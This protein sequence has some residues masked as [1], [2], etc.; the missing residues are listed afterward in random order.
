MKRV[1]IKEESLQNLADAVRA[2][3]GTTNTYNIDEAVA[4]IADIDSSLTPELEDITITQNGI[5]YPNAYGFYQVTVDV[6]S[7][8]GGGSSDIPEEAF[9]LGENCN[10]KFY[11]GSWNWFIEN[12]GNRI[13]TNIVYAS[14]MFHSVLLSEIPFDIT[15]AEGQ[16]HQCVETFAYCEYLR[17]LPNLIN[18][19]PNCTSNMFI[20]CRMLAEL[21]DIDINYGY[22][23]SVGSP[24][25]YSQNSMF[26]E[27]NNLR[28]IPACW[29]HIP[30]MI[31]LYNSYF[32]NGF[33]NCYALD[34][35]TD[36]PI[37][38]DYSQEAWYDNAFYNTFYNCSRL[39]NITF[40]TNDD[41]TPITVDWTNQYI[42]LT[43]VGFGS[44]W[45]EMESVGITPDNKVYNDEK[46]QALK[47]SS[48]WWTEE[49]QYSRYNKTS[50]I[51]TIN[52]LPDTSAYGGVN[53]ICFFGNAGSNTDGGAI[54]TLTEEEIAIATAKGWTIT[55]A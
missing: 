3:T 47:Y 16:S 2:K 44:G 53:T 11:S 36:L 29:L 39:K 4:A 25:D 10:Y 21:P 6:A 8:G 28:R 48:D 52:S 40:K 13:T 24:W 7:S 55:F 12:Y 22:C 45:W 15:F 9:Y 31:N 32:N 26:C 50:A 17:Q 33:C 30:P 1:A 27:C 14:Y 38:T 34:E 23:D 49:Y 51:N 19:T 41:G 54:N 5:Y 20:A 42:D 18:F 46:Y 43:T 35:L 37:P